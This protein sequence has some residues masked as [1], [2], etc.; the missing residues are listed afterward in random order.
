MVS[1][2]NSAAK[3]RLSKWLTGLGFFICAM[4]AFGFASKFGWFL[5]LA[6]HFRIQY[7]LTLVII[8]IWLAGLRKPVVATVCA[9]FSVINLALI[10][11]FYVP[12]GATAQEG[13]TPVLRAFLL[14]VNARN[15]K[16]DRVIQEITAHDPH[17]VL[18]LEVTPTWVHELQVLRERYPYRLFAPQQDNFGIALLSKLPWKTAHIRYFETPDRPTVVAHL[19]VH[20]QRLTLLGAHPSPPMNPRMA[21]QRNR[22]LQA[23]AHFLGPIDHAV[24]LLGDLNITPWSYYFRQLLKNADLRNSA[25][26]RGVMPSWPTSFAPLR[27]PIDHCLISEDITIHQRRNGSNVGSDHYP[28]IVDFSLGFRQSLPE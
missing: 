9:V 24:L 1:L 10:L 2:G 25:S 22:Q 16:Y 18:L 19:R 4:S 17:M 7:C 23:I 14:N 8:A 13:S 5:E 26:G 20:G 11:P 15:H 6:S 21:R 3:N 27:I 12:G 28:V